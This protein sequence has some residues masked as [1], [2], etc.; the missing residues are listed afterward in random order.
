M[1]HD[2]FI[3][4]KFGAPIAPLLF[5]NFLVTLILIIVVLGFIVSMFS[6]AMSVK[7]ITDYSLKQY[8]L[9]IWHLQ[10]PNF[11][12]LENAKSL[13]GYETIFKLD[14]KNDIKPLLNIQKGN[15]IQVNG[16]QHD[17]DHT[18]LAA[19]IYDGTKRITF[20]LPVEEKWQRV[21]GHDNY[22]NKFFVQF[23]KRKVFEEL[24]N[25]VSAAWLKNIDFIIVP[26]SDKK[27]LQ[28]MRENKEYEM[29]PKE[30]YML[31]HLWN[32]IFDKNHNYWSDKSK[33]YFAPR[34]SKKLRKQIERY[35][36]SR[37]IRTIYTA[38][39]KPNF[40]LPTPDNFEGV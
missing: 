16:Y 30:A 12:R 25:K 28:E 32:K 2:D 20:W 4:K 3:L 10:Q 31:Q 17:G 11:Y 13:Q 35:Y 37:R 36:Y 33:K 22:N 27:R 6:S 29:L 7:V 38:Q 34:K 23:D 19:E 9:N 18:W 8:F 1:N 21:W 15:V 40:K 26:K 39:L 5:G 24:R 14:E